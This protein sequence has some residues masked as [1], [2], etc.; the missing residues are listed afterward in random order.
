MPDIFETL[1][2]LS[3][4]FVREIQFAYDTNI[5]AQ[6]GSVKTVCGRR[7][8]CGSVDGFM[9]PSNHQYDKSLVV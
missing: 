1:R 2:G 5:H 3:S 8:N 6:Q 7:F 9:R 4:G